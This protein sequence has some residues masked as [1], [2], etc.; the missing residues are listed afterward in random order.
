MQIYAPI[1]RVA[2]EKRGALGGFSRGLVQPSRATRR[3]RGAPQTPQQ[4]RSTR[5]WPGSGC[6]ARL[7]RALAT[8]G[9]SARSRPREPSRGPGRGAKGPQGHVNSGPI[10]ASQR[11]SPAREARITALSHETSRVATPAAAAA[12]TRASV[13]APPQPRKGPG[14]PQPASHLIRDATPRLRRAPRREPGRGDSST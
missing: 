6:P 12:V 8:R 10:L 11:H 2:F 9:C 5:P 4:P 14:Q 13:R 7:P 3:G 1:W